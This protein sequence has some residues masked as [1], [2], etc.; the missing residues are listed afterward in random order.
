M[1]WRRI[2]VYY[3]LCVV[4]G[5]YYLL[6]ERR[7]DPEK[8]IFQ[9]RPVQQ[10]RFL[11]IPREQIRTLTLRRGNGVVTVHR[12][13]QGWRVTE[14][15]GAMVTSALVTSLLESLTV[16]K[17]IQIVAE[18]PEDLTP[19]GLAV[20]QAEILIQGATDNVVTTI[21]LGD[22][23]PTAT[24]VYARRDN[25]PEVVLLGFSVKYYGDLIFE[26]AGIKEHNGQV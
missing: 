6:F 5:G 23:N 15:A 1:S 19:Y 18:A 24:A 8:P 25:S 26:A 2:A 20:P 12:T 13:D 21:F 10:S 14:P 3:T 11:P 9:P 17:E 7:P 22:R 16:E 4:L